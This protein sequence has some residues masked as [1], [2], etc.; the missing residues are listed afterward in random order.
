MSREKA[1]ALRGRTVV[2]VEGVSDQVALETLARRQDRNLEV[3]GI[4]TLPIRGAQAIGRFLQ[5]FGPQGYDTRLA[6][7]CDAA[8][9]SYFR[10]A[11]ERAGFGVNLTR[12]ELERLGFYVCVEDLED[13]LIRS[14][15]AAT[16]ETVIEA[17]G[18][19]RP[20]RT[21]QRQPAQQGRPIERQLR[22]FMGTHSGRKA[23]YARALV[24]AMDLGR[25]PPPLDRL[26]AHLMPSTPGPS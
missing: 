3:E 6:G 15:G 18:D 2:I 8:E 13:E 24:D 1:E 20:F 25:F 26:L 19:L 7:L 21:F 11:L 12:T 22:R 17:Q 9:E 5:L 16:V 4:S 23:Q 14:L 10:S